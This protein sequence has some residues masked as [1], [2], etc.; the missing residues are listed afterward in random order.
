MLRAV[1]AE[2]LCAI[3]ETFYAA[4]HAA[5]EDLTQDLRA[6]MNVTSFNSAKKK[7]FKVAIDDAI[8]QIKIAIGATKGSNELT[9]SQDFKNGLEEY[10]KDFYANTGA[11]S[12]DDGE[13]RSEKLHLLYNDFLD[14]FTIEKCTRFNYL[15]LIT[16]LLFNANDSE[17][18]K[19]EILKS[20]YDRGK[21][22]DNEITKSKTGSFLKWWNRRFMDIVRYG[23]FFGFPDRRARKAQLS[24]ARKAVDSFLR[25]IYASLFMGRTSVSFA[26]LKTKVNEYESKNNCCLWTPSGIR[27]KFLPNVFE[28]QSGLDI[29]EEEQFL[30]DYRK[31]V[32]A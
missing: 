9:F 4:L 28:A 20:L 31:T 5:W 26:V 3:E 7:A 10:C 21:V 13:A 6:K 15:S 8:T 17:F 29:A 24:T 23:A 12:T 2:D 11:D 25:K 30:N 27:K 1:W 19:F 18:N 14:H 22:V 32:A 16:I